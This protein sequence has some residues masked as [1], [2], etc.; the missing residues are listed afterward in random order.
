[1][2]PKEEV[3]ADPVCREFVE[4]EGMLC[5]IVGEDRRVVVYPCVENKLMNFLLVRT[6]TQYSRVSTD[7]IRH[8]STQ[9][10]NH[11]RMM[12]AGTNKVTRSVCL[13]VVPAWH[14]KFVLF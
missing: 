4:Q 10:A 2:V 1:L 14:L 5:M 11:A 13:P 7:F 8:R 3:M 6:A 12:L 9:V